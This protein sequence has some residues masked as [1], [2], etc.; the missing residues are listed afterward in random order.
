MQVSYDS[1][2]ILNSDISLDKA[3]DYALEKAKSLGI[4]LVIKPHP[5]ETEA[6]VLKKLQKLKVN[7]NVHIVNDNV[8]DIIPYASHV[9]TINSTVGL[10]TLILNK[11]LTVLG[12]AF[13]SNFTEKELKQYIC[14]YLMDIDFFGND[15]IKKESIK[16]LLQ[17]A[18]VED[19]Y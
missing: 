2:I 10:E 18:S 7:D 11:P 13:Y 16:L 9:I 14:G 15:K 8:F 19:T 17:R 1:Q 6:W 5:Q 4:D 3:I 12:K